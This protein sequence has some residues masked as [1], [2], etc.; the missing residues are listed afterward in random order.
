[1]ADTFKELKR[2]RK[3]DFKQLRENVRFNVKTHRKTNRKVVIL[4]V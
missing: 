1:M 2:K 3:A 4:V